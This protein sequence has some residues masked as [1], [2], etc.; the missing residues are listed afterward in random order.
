MGEMSADL[1]HPVLFAALNGTLEEFGI[2]ILQVKR[3]G[4]TTIHAKMHQT[5]R[6][7]MQPDIGN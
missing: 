1:L 6:E 7:W 2:P 3:E 4:M 5:L